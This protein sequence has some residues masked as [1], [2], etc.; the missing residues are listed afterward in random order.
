MINRLNIDIAWSPEEYA[1]AAVLAGEVGDEMISRLAWLRMKPKTIVDV[2]AGNAAMSVKLKALYQDAN[3]FALD[4]SLDMI[5]AAKSNHPLCICADAYSLP[6]ANQSIDFIFANLILPW[7]PTFDDVK[8]IMQEWK[9]VLRPEGVLMFS[10]LGPDT[11]A[12]LQESHAVIPQL[13]DIHHLGDLLLQDGWSDPVLDVMRYDIHYSDKNKM[14]N[15]LVAT[16]MLNESTVTDQQ[17]AHYEVIYAHAFAPEIKLEQKI[18]EGVVRIPLS[19]LRESLLN[20]A[21]R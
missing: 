20:K 6:F 18:E 14:M 9:R 16:G 3:V 2:G 19:A 10:C 11:L 13:T 21:L 1:Q 12:A 5:N 4:L 15:E 7:T 8:S 17:L